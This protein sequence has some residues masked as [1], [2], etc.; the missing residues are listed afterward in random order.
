MKPLRIGHAS[1][2]HLDFNYP[3]PSQMLVDAD[4]LFIAGDTIE[5][6]WFEF[7]MNPNSGNHGEAQQ[8]VHFF[9]KIS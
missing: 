6:K 9:R 5:A 1:D 8:L 2:L 3:A 4:Y 7:A